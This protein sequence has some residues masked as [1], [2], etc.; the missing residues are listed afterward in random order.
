L[1]QA[2]TLHTPTCEVTIQ[3]SG[4]SK[5]IAILEPL[6]GKSGWLSCGKF[7]VRTLE[8]E[9]H[10]VLSG[11][12]DEGDALDAARL[13]RFFD[14]PAM[15][16]N[17]LAIPADAEAR[18]TELQTVQQ[19]TILEAL[20]KRN[21]DRFDIEMDKLEHWADDRRASLKVELDDLEEAIKET[22]KAARLAPNL[23][24][25]LAKQQ[26]L[27]KLDAKRDEVW[28]SYDEA[29]KDIEKQKDN[30]LDEISRR[31]EQ[32]TDTQVLFTIRWRL[33]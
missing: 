28:R 30:L 5:K 14:L 26:A 2:K 17:E 15:Q 25:K 31:L 1:E 24:D 12:T 32:N 13:E 4:G 11:M 16:G 22:R 8:E 18:L 21:A 29:S 7:S 3:Y 27:K 9:D 20:T 10:L 6:I 33:K 23:P 19:K